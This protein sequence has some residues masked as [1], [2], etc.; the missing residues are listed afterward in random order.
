MFGTDRRAV[1]LPDT[2]A[3]ACLAGERAGVTRLGDLTQFGCEGIPVFHAVRPRSRSL[4]VSQGKGLTPMAAK[5]SALL[6][7]VEFHAAETLPAP[8][9]L[10]AAGARERA[11]W[12]DGRHKLAINLDP[13]RYRGWLDGKDL[14]TGR[15]AKLPWEILSLD[16]TREQSEVPV[17]SI[18]LAT[19]NT[20]AE[21]LCA[22]IAEVLEHDLT[23]RFVALS[24]LAK[25]ARQVDLG[26]IDEPPLRRVLRRI[27]AAGLTIRVWSLGQDI[28][29]AAFRCVILAR[30]Q[31]L[32]TMW[33]MMGS[34]CHPL[35]STAF[36]RAVLEAVQTRATV[37]AGA[38][39][40]LVG[41]GYRD[42]ELHGRDMLFDALAFGE[43]QLDWRRTPDKPLGS[44]EQALDFLL[45]RT[46]AISSTSVVAFDHLPPVPG[47]HLAH[48][49]APRL[50]AMHRQR[51]TCA[52]APAEG[53][54]IKLTTPARRRRPVL[55]A[56][57]SIAML[58]VPQS[59]E[60]RPP[61]VWGD[62]AAL[63]DDP[64]PVVGLADGY[65]AVAPTVWHKE[66]LSLLAV[67]VRVVGAASLGALRAAEL[68][69]FGM[70]GVGEIYRAYRDGTLVR[71]DAVML[72]HAPERLRYAPITVPLVD[73]E[74]A[75]HVC[76]LTGKPLRMLLRIVRTTAYDK[77]TWPD[78]L[79]EFERR[80]GTPAPVDLASLESVPSVKVRD[81]A[82]L[83]ARMLELAQEKAMPSP[84]PRPPLTTHYRELLAKRAPA[85]CA[86]LCGQDRGSTRA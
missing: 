2:Y 39:D 82:L 31:E 26:S 14:L 43:G 50:L 85:T 19:G 70:E 41:E 58:D 11:I 6:E 76:G 5:V 72:L 21:A 18:G 4:T 57:P 35:R 83:I 55:F 15:E 20:R 80:T 12:A 8:A 16:F 7:A 71:D 66:I 22:G 13:S 49:F 36:L 23:A 79:A 61:A 64:P 25:L 62:L 1:P 52:V 28:G 38:R 32:E 33:P 42:G 81:A 9:T 65:F 27:A 56:G 47:L 67:G 3:L 73:A 84:L 29:V 59:I 53:A 60:V 75:L 30:H 69:V 63:L 44:T 77:R 46:Q 34:G 40:D 37:I 45:G 54:P 24:P 78:C 68:D 86:A 74:H 48:V 10:A 17:N 51:H